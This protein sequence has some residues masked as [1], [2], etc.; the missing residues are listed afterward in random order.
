[1]K[2][3]SRGSALV[4][5]ALTVGVV[6]MML[7]GTVQFGV[8]GFRQIAQDGAAFV[9]ARTYAQTPAAGATSAATTANGAFDAIP[10]STIA[11]VPSGTTV[12]ATVASTMQTP[13]LPGSPPTVSLRS[14]ATGR[15]PGPA[16]LPGAFAVTSVLS[17][18]RSAAGVPAPTRI[19]VVAQ[20]GLPPFNCDQSGGNIGCDGAH[21]HIDYP[22]RFGEWN[23]RMATYA[24]L[25]FPALRPPGGPGTVW[26]PA[27]A[28]SPLSAIYSWDSGMGC[29]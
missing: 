20:P 10:S 28:T 22:G 2:A 5:T 4:E 9:A 13:S 21:V 24:G 1:M 3:A 8:L 23:C 27:S 29:A 26:D 6:L 16:V 14:G 18:F 15:L 11:V 12:T 17:N 7:L 25:T 19:F